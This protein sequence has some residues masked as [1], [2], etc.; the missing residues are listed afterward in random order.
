MRRTQSQ[1]IVGGIV[2]TLLGVGAGGSARAEGEA[3]A[4]VAALQ[5]KAGAVQSYQA[6]FTLTVTE[7]KTPSVLK[8]TL[9]YRQPDKRRIEFT[10]PPADDVAQ[11]VVSDGVTEW[12]YFPGRKIAHKTDWAKMQAAGGPPEASIIRGP[13]QPFLDLKPDSIKVLSA[14][15]AGQVQFEA[16]PAPTLIAEAPF[17]PG[18]IR[19]TVSEGDGLVRRL[20]MTDADGNEV[21]SQEYSRITVDPPVDAAMFRFTPPDGVEVVDISEERARAGAAPANDTSEEAP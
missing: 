20:S 11:L 7:E 3:A 17:A 12:Q 14:T 2:A 8:G 4:R 16:E 19:V 18:K 5:A 13:H 6:E 10:G 1:W 21:L 15:G 9:T